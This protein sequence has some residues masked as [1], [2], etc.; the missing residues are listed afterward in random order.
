MRT[1]RGL[2]VA[3]LVAALSALAAAPAQGLLRLPLLVAA[4]PAAAPPAA[5]PAVPLVLGGVPC[6]LLP[7]AT[8]TAA[9]V[10]T[11][12]CPGVR[13]GA[14]VRSEAGT[15]SFNFLFVGSD[16]G[17]YMGT[18]GHCVLPT[19]VE[20]EEAW[21]AGSGPVARDGT[22]ARVGEFAYA[23]LRSPMDFALVRLDPGVEASP[24]MCWFG[25]PTYL[26]DT[27]PATPVILNHYGNGQLIGDLLPARS[28]V[29]LGMPEPDHVF[30][31]GLALPGDS[32]SGLMSADGGAV[33]VV[34][35]LGLQTGSI[36][37]GGVDAGTMGS[38]RLRPQ[39][40]QAQERLGI[41]L[42]LQTAPLL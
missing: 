23:V 34:V 12:S 9:P 10:G 14:V 11:G 40:A 24:Q 17:R 31:V 32:G 1:P 3:L 37:L 35:T 13:P 21:P 16:G 27:T 7:P 39:L 19:D 36:G 2:T 4:P 6:R 22:G 33:G 15:C 8:P 26:N 29:A 28:A 42:E 41:T 30:A 25:G 5:A 38:T 20:S 18:A